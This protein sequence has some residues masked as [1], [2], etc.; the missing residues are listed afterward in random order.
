MLP[1]VIGQLARRWVTPTKLSAKIHDGDMHI[2][3]E[4]QDL[5]QADAERVTSTLQSCTLVREVRFTM[6][7]QPS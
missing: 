6:P 7:D 2:E 4:T 1:R 3:F 5:S